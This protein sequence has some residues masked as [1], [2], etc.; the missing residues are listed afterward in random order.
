MSSTKNHN[1]WGKKKIYLW[2]GGPWEPSHLQESAACRRHWGATKIT[3]V[4]VLTELTLSWAG[5]Q[6]CKEIWN[7]RSGVDKSSGGSR[8]GKGQ[9]GKTQGL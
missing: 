7:V 1:N 2:L 9:K 6:T 8:A 3:N 5:R 4:S